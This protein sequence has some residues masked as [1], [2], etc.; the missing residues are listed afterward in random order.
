[1]V[2]RP[3]LQME[4]TILSRDSTT[5]E[6]HS[7]PKTEWRKSRVLTIDD[8]PIVCKFVDS[9]LRRGEFTCIESLHDS[10]I[11]LKKIEEFK[12]DL[13]LLDINMP[14]VDGLE[15]LKQIKSDER[16]AD[17]KVVMLSTAGEESKW[18]SLELGAFDFIDKPVD[19]IELTL[20]VRHAARSNEPSAPWDD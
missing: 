1:M 11:A 4:N 5:M 16:F 8:E 14:G 20:R 9:T 15:L 3:R 18:K 7:K 2:L 10:T 19:Y 6:V 12:P 13:I 17:I